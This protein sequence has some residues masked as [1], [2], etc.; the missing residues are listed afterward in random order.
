MSKDRSLT[1]LGHKLRVPKSSGA[2]CEF[3]IDELCA[4]GLGEPLGAQA[5]WFTMFLMSV[6]R[7]SASMSAS[8]RK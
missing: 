7:M 2:V 3:T 1:V 6:R 4:E 8:G 5:I